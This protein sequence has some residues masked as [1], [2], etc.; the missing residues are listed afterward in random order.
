VVGRAVGATST[1]RDYR[2]ADGDWISGGRRL[3]PIR[4]VNRASSSIAISN[5]AF[6]AATAEF[7]DQWLTLR[8]GA[9]VIREYPENE[10]HKA[11]A[12]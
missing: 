7:P 1:T 2:A 10:T 4:A 12:M 8:K 9:M 6:D 11:K 5:A 3:L